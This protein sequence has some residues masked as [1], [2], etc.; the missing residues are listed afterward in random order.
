MPTVMFE[1]KLYSRVERAARERQQT[2]DDTLAEAV[3]QY[4]WELD[5]QTITQESARYYEQWAELKARYLGKF[6][7]MQNGAVL[8][9]DSDFAVLRQRIRQKFGDAPIMITL[10][11]DE[12][13]QILTR[14]GFR[15]AGD[16]A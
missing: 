12:P 8:D 10:V 13:G 16:A 3:R 6:I 9:H 5:R 14:R 1:P 2:V 4:L 11:T 7:A 15:L